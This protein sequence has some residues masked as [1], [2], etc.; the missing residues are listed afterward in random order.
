M[1]K[2][3]E[4]KN[5]EDYEIWTDSGWQD[6]THIHKTVSYDVWELKTESFSLECADEHI[7]IRD[8]GEQVFVCD[9]VVGDKIKTENGVEEVISVYKTDK[10]QE[11]MYDVTVDSEDHTFYSSGILSHNTTMSSIFL[12]YY[13][14]FNKDKTVAVMANKE[15]AAKEV[16]RRVK[17][18]YS[19]LPLWLQQGIRKWNETSIELEN[20]CRLICATTSADSISGETVSLLY[21]DEFAKVPAHVA[22]EFVTATMPVVSSGKDS[23]VIIVSTPNG[24]NVF[25]QYWVNATRTDGKNNN[26]FPMKVNWWDHPERDD[27]W[28]KRMLDTFNGDEKKFLQEYSCLKSSTYINIQDTETGEIFT[29]TVGELYNLL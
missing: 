11:H 10:P 26:F 12:V 29:L 16:L 3:I 24:L 9:L 23:K 8:N 4:T 2:I 13:M 1:G 5:L 22:E 18:G 17:Q 6:I 20:G 7:V 21:L 15:A 14:L 28:K 25:H 27:E 19:L